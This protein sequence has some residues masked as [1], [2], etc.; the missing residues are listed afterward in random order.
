MRPMD[1]FCCFLSR[2]EER[3]AN[4]NRQGKRTV[5]A[6]GVER[7]ESALMG[8]DTVRTVSVLFQYTPIQSKGRSL[9]L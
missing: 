5:D 7:D 3:D 8:D 9:I 4:K 6:F 1:P 2:E